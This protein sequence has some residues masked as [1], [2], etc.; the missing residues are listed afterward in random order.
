M[1]YLLLVRHSIPIVSIGSKSTNWPL[2]ATGIEKAH[3]LAIRISKYNPMLIFTSTERKAIETAKIIAE[4]NQSTIEVNSELNEQKR[5]NLDVLS[6]DMF[7]EGIMKLFNSPKEVAFG[8]ESANQAYERIN[9]AIN[10]IEEGQIEK[11]ICIITHGVVMALYLSQYMNNRPYDIWS[12]L[13]MP[14]CFV[15]SRN[16]KEVIEIVRY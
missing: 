16:N 14:S 9:S 10:G 13:P 2:S 1:K 15:L 12:N 8:M 6:N 3:D 4:T 7:D 11:N 5:D